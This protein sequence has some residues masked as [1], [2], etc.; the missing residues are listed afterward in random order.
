MSLKLPIELL[1]LILGY[2]SSRDLSSFLTINRTFFFIITRIL[3]KRLQD[4][5]YRGYELIFEAYQPSEKNTLPY[6]SSHFDHEIYPYCTF[7]VGGDAGYSFTMEYEGFVQIIVQVNVIRQVQRG[8]TNYLS[9]DIAEVLEIIR[10]YRNSLDEKKHDNEIVNRL[11]SIAMLKSS[12]MAR[13]ERGVLLAHHSE[14]PV[15][16]EIRYQQIFLNTGFLLA[17]IEEAEIVQLTASA[18]LVVAV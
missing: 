12:F 1:P 14:I 15:E 3:R 13:T 2:C 11:G 5:L 8:D 9:A 4:Q 10:L 17:K 7:Q 18:P 6:L 16:Y